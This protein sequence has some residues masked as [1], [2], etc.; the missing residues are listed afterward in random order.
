MLHIWSAL[1]ILLTTH[2]AMPV[3]HCTGF[4]AGPKATVHGAPFVGQTNDAEGGPGDSLVFVEAADHAPG[5]M[6]PILD[7]D[8]SQKIG[9]IPQVNH[10]YAYSYLSYGVMN[11]HKLAFGETTCSG[12]F[13][14]ASLAHNGT[15]L[16]SNE[17]LSKIALERCKTARCAIK[18]MGNLAVKH[19]GFYGEG[20]DVDT[21][22][23]TLLIADTIEAWVFHILADPSGT[24]AIWAAQR[25]PDDEVA[26]VPNTY[27]IRAMDLTDADY[28]MASENAQ[29]IAKKYGFWDG[30][31]QFD[32]S[33]A[34]SLGEYSNPHYAAR[35]MWRAYDLIAPSLKLDPSK[36][37]TDTESGY[38][39][40]VKPDRPIS[41]ADVMNVYRDYYEGTPFSLVKDEISA[42]PF[43]SPLRIASGP[44][45]P[46][47]L[48]GAWERPI[49]IYRGN[50][51]V[52]SILHPEGHGVTWF[53]S[54]TPHASVFAPAY[55]SAATRVPRCYVVD[56]TKNVDRHSLFWAAT[57][58]SN[59]AFGSMFSHAIQDVRT[60]QAE[61]E[62]PLF[63]LAERLVTAPAAEH[64]SLLE[65]AAEQVHSRWWD[66][67]WDLM[68]KYNDGYI[69]S[70]NKDGTINS[71]AVGYPSWWLKAANFGDGI[72]P[73]SEVTAEFRSL[74]DRMAKAK[75][76]MDKIN[77]DRKPPKPIESITS[78]SGVVV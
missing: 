4:V 63:K 51:A 25:V 17:E 8:T 30:K 54:H 45:E 28:F 35:R 72:G 14:A 60:A 61:L 24:S 27:V 75:D 73:S 21:G 76:L 58:V 13:W 19:G 11:E 56:K 77:K 44:A 52:L 38:P 65:Q 69:I 33:K 31:A 64:N 62:A 74:Q 20:T 40:A 67:F 47:F 16:F 36:V 7:Q 23:E 49:S 26:V 22:S 3:D 10:T 48:T 50:Y 39:F 12:R 59:W 42:G 41:M 5:S 34:Y 18:L 9:E 68:G 15:A 2:G 55:T 43:N 32:F 6:R 57:A 70:R 37:I 46:E 29:P 1:S 53:A 66:L 78:S 71:E